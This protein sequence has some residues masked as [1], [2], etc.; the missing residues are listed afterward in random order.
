[1]EAKVLATNELG[2]EP[3]TPVILEANGT[4]VKLRSRFIGSEQDCYVILS[5]TPIQE[6]GSS[7]MSQVIRR[8]TKVKVFFSREGSVHGFLSKVLASTTKPFMHL[9]LSYPGNLEACN[10][11]MTERTECHLPAVVDLFGGELEGM[12]TNISAG[13]CALSLPLPGE[14]GVNT[15]H[16][17][18]RLSLRFH[19]NLASR[20]Y[21][22]A[23]RVMNVRDCNDK[24]L[25]GLRFEDLDKKARHSVVEFIRYVQL[26][27][28]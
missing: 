27:R 19:I 21:R 18:D 10:L 15:F 1:M 25:L 14:E 17:G 2:L 5:L 24:T 26:H 22:A 4:G 6:Q 16:Q 11:R 13:G 7:V 20:E 28:I 12:V 23:C 9:Y 3:G 8:G